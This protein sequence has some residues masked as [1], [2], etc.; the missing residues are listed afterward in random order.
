ML[1][2]LVCC[3]FHEEKKRSFVTEYLVKKNEKTIMNLRKCVT[4][5]LFNRDPTLMCS[6][7]IANFT[8]YLQVIAKILDSIK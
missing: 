6:V 8:K 3:V 4:K 5:K 2:L 7:V 1:I